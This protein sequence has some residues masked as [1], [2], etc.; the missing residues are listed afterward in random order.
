MVVPFGT[1]NN[2][3]VN[4]FFYPTQMVSS[5]QDCFVGNTAVIALFAP[6]KV[7]SITSFSNQFTLFQSVYYVLQLV[8]VVISFLG[9]RCSYVS[10]PKEAEVVFLLTVLLVW[11]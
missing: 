9:F 3:E 5:S 6:A 4:R 7:V 8:S 2:V 1:S 10:R 11:L